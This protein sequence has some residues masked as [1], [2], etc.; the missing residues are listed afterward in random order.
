MRIFLMIAAVCGMW[1]TSVAAQQIQAADAHKS[2]Q[3][4]TQQA[5]SGQQNQATVQKD[6]TQDQYTN[7][8]RTSQKEAGKT[9]QDPNYR[10]HNGRWWYWQNNN[11]LMWNGSRWVTPG[12][13]QARSYSYAPRRSY[14]FIPTEDGLPRSDASGLQNGINTPYTV[15]YQKV[16][17]SYGVRSAGAKVLGDY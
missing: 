5:D 11:W 17:P 8:Q 10:R 12:E 2:Q 7:Q 6:A 16:I 15:E 4:S 14:S 9:Q 3:P 1:A 13:R